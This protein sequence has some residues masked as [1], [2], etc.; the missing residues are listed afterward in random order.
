MD[1]LQMESPDVPECPVCLQTYDGEYTIPRVLACGHTTCESCLKSLPQKYPLTIR[2]PAC[3]Q[4]VKF[5]SQGPSFLPKNIDLLRLIPT[6]SQLQNPPK[7]HNKAQNNLQHHHHQVD[8][9]RL[10]SDEFYAMWKNWVLPNDSVLVEEKENGFGCLKEGNRKVRLFKFAGVSFPVS[11]K[12]SVFKLSYDA[13][14]M[15]CLYGMKKEVREELSS[16]LKVCS[17][18][19][20]TCKVYGLWADLKYGVLYLV[21][22][23]LNGILDQL[24]EFEDG[25]NKNGLSS[26]AMMGMEM[27]EA[28]IASHVEG[29]C[30]GCLGLSCFEMD[31]FGHVNLSLSEV[32]VTGGAVHEVI[33]ETGFDGRRIC[34][35]EIGK[36]VSGSFEREAFLS[37]EMLFEI[38]KKDAIEVDCV[39]FKHSV[40]LS[41]DVWS[42][43]CILLRLLIG[44]Q[45]TE[46]LVDY[47]DNFISEVSEENSLDFS[48]LFMGL[49]EKVR[50]L[51]GSKVGE[52]C[53]SLQKILCRCLNIDP[54]S[55]P[56]VVEVWK[57]VR[58][59][60]TKLQLD[61]MLRLDGTVHEKSKVHCLALGEF[62]LLPKKISEI[63]KK[64]E[65]LG[66]DNSS[67]EKPN[68]GEGM[69]VDK[70]FF[71]GLLEGK[72]KLKDMQGHLDCVTGL[73]IGGGY[74][75]SSSFD[76]S[77]QVWSL[78]DFSHLHTFKGHEHKVMAVIYVDEEQPLC[79][80]GDSGGGIFIWS[81]TIPLRQEPLKKWYEQKDWR[82]SGIH[83]L[84]TA[85]NGYLYTGSGDRSVKA[86]SLQDGILLS[87]MDGHRSVVSTLAACDGIL[88]SGSW[89]GTIRLWSLSDHSLLTVLGEDVPGTV[90]SVLSLFVCQNQLVAAHENGHI[91]R[92]DVFLKSMQ[93][94]NGSIFAIC[95]EGRY[96]FTGGWD[97]TI[98]VQELSGDEFQVDARS[99][100]SV[101]GGS[102]VTSLLYSQGK[103]FVGYGDRTIQVYHEQK[104]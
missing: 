48:G 95:M 18:N 93:P 71:Y 25:L 39:S 103:L 86:W 102:A 44:K 8:S 13:G 14:I 15:N 17:K 11:E 23:R 101:P 73:A 53:E 90:T 52:E 38:L 54:E 19:S 99:I 30:M 40:I 85:G 83:A 79:V 36:L 65:V 82:Y 58:E 75:F 7:P 68:Q 55:R 81:I 9:V 89:D 59:L 60:I 12:S 33:M 2:C 87:T 5:P 78:Q 104:C 28:V 10:W 56:L 70:D 94:H 29:L 76:K 80:S 97:K 22:E 51:L 47:V 41:S 66:A 16:I 37:P 6:T 98:N 49:M 74:L 84:A 43:A 31:D 67:A 42:L 20:R 34:D 27:C 88:Y 46:E 57:C 32:L 3:I 61:S 64:D 62:S 69:R 96:L 77:V 92:N 50:A 100:G 1:Q 4:L 72:V 35:K 45:F 91:W 63:L 24:P 21:F 26:F